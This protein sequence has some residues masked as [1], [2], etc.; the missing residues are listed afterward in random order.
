MAR[1]KKEKDAAFEARPD[2]QA[3]DAFTREILKV[4][5]TELDR[6]EEEE[7]SKKGK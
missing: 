4:S 2:M 1:K 5:K 6:R 7:R 3:L